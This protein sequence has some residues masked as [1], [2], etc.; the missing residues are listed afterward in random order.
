MLKE[1][2]QG[3]FAELYIKKIFEENEI[4][5]ELNNK[6]SRKELEQYDMSIEINGQKFFV[7][8][9]FDLMS[10]L[11]G[12]LAIEYFNCK[13]KKPSGL[14]STKSHIWAIV[15]NNP[16]TAWIVNTNILRNYITVNKPYK[17][18]KRGGDNNS[19]MYLYKKD[20]LL[21]KLFHNIDDLNKETFLKIINRVINESTSK[22]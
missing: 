7:E 16:V 12:N 11:T 22:T 14:T 9:K 1:K 19:A 10:S 6:K 5:V 4:P 8:V 20:E 13:L 17:D 21:T 2:Q 18:I 3:D 15:L